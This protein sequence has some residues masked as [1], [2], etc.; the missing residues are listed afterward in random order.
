MKSAS[1]LQACNHRLA[2]CKPATVGWTSCKPCNF[3]PWLGAEFC[4][5]TTLFAQHFETATLFS[6]PPHSFSFFFAFG[7]F[8]M[9]TSDSVI[10]GPVD[11]LSSSSSSLPSIASTDAC[12]LQQTSSSD[13]VS[14]GNG[15]IMVN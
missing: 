14:G 7:C 1:G 15:E 5:C 8:E 12:Q 11:S 9:N 3:R 4:N 10:V 13:V 2:G 6:F